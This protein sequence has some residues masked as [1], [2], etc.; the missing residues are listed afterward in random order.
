MDT[1]DSNFFHQYP[2]NAFGGPEELRKACEGDCSTLDKR[3][4]PEIGI[5]TPGALLSDSRI[6]QC[7]NL[8]FIVIDPFNPKYLGPNS[9]D[10]RL[11]SYYWTG[12]DQMMAVH[13]NSKEN[14]EH[15]W[16]GPFCAHKEIVIYPGTTILAHTIEKVG[17]QHG[18]TA[19]MHARSTI[20]RC[21]L[22]ICR[23]AG[24]GDVGYSGRWTMEISN[25]TKVP[26]FIPVGWRVAQMSFSYVGPTDTVYHGKYGQKEEWT[27]EDMLPKPWLDKP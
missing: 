6:K 13:L 27:P 3:P 14:I 11:G 12:N 2:I 22:S 23:C 8:G 24:F 26:I 21:G 18:Y 15:Y 4:Y 25:H 20:A 16:D 1:D 19:Q 5:D 17:G 7:L 10:V 9:Y